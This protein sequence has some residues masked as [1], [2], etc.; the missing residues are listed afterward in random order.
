MEA[1]VKPTVEALKSF[2]PDYIVPTHCTGRE[3]IQ[4]MEKEMPAAFIMNMSG[5]QLTFQA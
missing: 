3:S 4:L 5:T 2:K 1:V